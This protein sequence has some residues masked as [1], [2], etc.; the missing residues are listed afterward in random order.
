VVA[1]HLGAAAQDQDVVLPLA[2]RRA[3]R[4]A[5]D[6]LDAVAAQLLGERLA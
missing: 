6:Q 5:Q 1:A 3:R 4:R 2:P